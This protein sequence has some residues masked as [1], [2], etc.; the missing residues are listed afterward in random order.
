MQ[1]VISNHVIT[2]TMY[3][4][5]IPV[6][7]YHIHYP[8]FAT[9]CDAAS[10]QSINDYYAKRAR[11]IEENCRTVLYPQAA[12]HARY[13]QNNSPYNNYTLDVNYQITYNTGCI[14]S[15]YFDSYTYLGGAHGETQRTAD[16]WS[17]R[18]GAQLQ[19]PDVCPQANVST[20][21][22]P[23]CLENQVA[24]RLKNTPGSYF[25]NYKALLQESFH[26]ENF[27]LRPGCFVIFF[28]QYEIAPYST[29]IPEFCIPITICRM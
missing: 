17:F 9:T 3:V 4:R 28:Q 11:S 6:L 19:L 10:A 25:E 24:D 5:D 13:R 1:T 2:D 23:D 21:I 7:V 14:T 15:L 16:T 12:D 29:G 20:S 8:E 26:S 18:T 22:L 27:Y